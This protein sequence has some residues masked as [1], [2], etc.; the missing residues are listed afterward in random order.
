MK[1]ILNVNTLLGKRLAK[2]KIQHLRNMQKSKQVS[3]FRDVQLVEPSLRR[4]VQ[5]VLVGQQFFHDEVPLVSRK[6]DLKFDR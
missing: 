1:S 4:L 5:K 6:I 3:F 2:I